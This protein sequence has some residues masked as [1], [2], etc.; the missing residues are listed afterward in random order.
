MGL[1]PTVLQKP[2]IARLLSPEQRKAEKVTTPEEARTKAVNRDEAKAQSEI[3]GYLR[4]HDI[5]YIKPSMLKKSTLP[6]GWPDFTLAYR[7]T[8]LAL[9]VKVWGIKAEPHQIVMHTKL[10]KDGWRV[11][12]ISGVPD[13]QQIFR[14]IDGQRRDK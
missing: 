10:R 13:V 7:G 14:E 9:E 2:A 8:P 11:E 4:L 1:D 3:A 5:Q 12:V 6:S